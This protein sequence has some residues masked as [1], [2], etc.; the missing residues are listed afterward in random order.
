MMMKPWQAVLN[1][2]PSKGEKEEQREMTQV[3][4]R[5]AKTPKWLHHKHM[6]HTTEK[7]KI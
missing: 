3:Q 6:P 7:E 1:K 5:S 4:A 2:A